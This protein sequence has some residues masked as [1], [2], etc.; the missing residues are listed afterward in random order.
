MFS[1]FK[2]RTAWK[3]VEAGRD[4]GKAVAAKEAEVKTLHEALEKSRQELEEKAKALRTSLEELESQRT[5]AANAEIARDA[6]RDEHATL[7]DSSTELAS[8][9]EQL[10]ATLKSIMAE[11]QQAQELLELRTA[12]LKGAQAYLTKADQLS[13]AEVVKLVEGLNAEI[14]QTAAAIAEELSIAEKN[15][16]VDAKEQES[17]DMRHA[18]ART[19]EMIGSRATELLKASE[20]HEDPILVQIAV[21]AS[22]ARY[23]HW[24]IS[25]WAFESPDDEQMLSEIYERV[26]E[27][28]TW[29]GSACMRIANQ[30]NRGASRFGALEA[31]DACLPPANIRPQCRARPGPRSRR[32][33]YSGDSWKQRVPSR[34]AR[35]SQCP[36]WGRDIESC[37][38]VASLEQAG[39]RRRHVLRPG[40]LVYRFRST[41]QPHDDGRRAANRRA[42]YPG[43]HTLYNRPRT[44]TG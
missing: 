12:E 17:D 4:A 35:T 20:H 6:L 22:F 31:I 36:V 13:N 1:A 15:I 28:G 26:R 18:Y 29:F 34:T 32:L 9:N 21:Q 5:R 33:Q 42:L 2:L 23:T 38:D 41:L 44:C 27:T 19:E 25:S 39:W 3:H 43:E 8:T 40:S 37:E 24:M 7:V 11:R 30:W 10:R 16:D 14:L